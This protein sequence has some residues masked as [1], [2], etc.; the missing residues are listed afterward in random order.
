MQRFF[1]SPT[2]QI[3]CFIGT[4]YFFRFTNNLL[5]NDTGGLTTA[6]PVNIYFTTF[7]QPWGCVK[8]KYAFLTTSFS[9]VLC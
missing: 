4:S 1:D 8:N 3:F 9:D 5:H 2:Q 7:F 6:Q